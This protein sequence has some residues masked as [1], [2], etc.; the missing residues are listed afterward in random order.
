MDSRLVA[1]RAF[2]GEPFRRVIVDIGDK[3]IYLAIR[4]RSA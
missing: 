2:G 4:T 3:L 1:A